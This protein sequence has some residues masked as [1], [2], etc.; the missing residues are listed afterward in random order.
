MGG[1]TKITRLADLTNGSGLFL[2]I[3][4]RVIQ[5][6]SLVTLA[7]LSPLWQLKRHWT[8]ASHVRESPQSPC[9]RRRLGFTAP[10]FPASDAVMQLSITPSHSEADCAAREGTFPHSCAVC[11]LHFPEQRMASEEMRA[12]EGKGGV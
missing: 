4:R 5:A 7:R 2:W 1:T 12:E 11:A 10:G 9:Q 8:A 3:S 6:F